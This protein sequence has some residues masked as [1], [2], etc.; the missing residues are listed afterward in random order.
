[1]S[2]FKI[3][4]SISQMNS[5]GLNLSTDPHNQLLAAHWEQGRTNSVVLSDIKR[6][7]VML[8]LSCSRRC[9][10]TVGNCCAY[11]LALAL[12]LAEACSS[13]GSSCVAAVC[14]FT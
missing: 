2:V 7:C 5:E 6:N 8:S 3:R 11:T 13:P 9:L 1:M 4:F 14:T 12:S 10:I